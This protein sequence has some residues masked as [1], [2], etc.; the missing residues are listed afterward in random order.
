MNTQLDRITLNKDKN[1]KEREAKKE[2]KKKG[3]WIKEKR[4]YKAKKTKIEQEIPLLTFA[5]IMFNNMGNHVFSQ[6]RV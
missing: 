6:M 1:R 4:W 3:G 5:N 2:R